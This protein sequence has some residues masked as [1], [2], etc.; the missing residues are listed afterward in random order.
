MEER[1]EGTEHEPYK[2][3]LKGFE[4]P[5]DLLLHLVKTHE[6]DIFDIPVAFITKKYLEYLDLM[7]TL[8]IDVAGE[9]VLMAA[10]LAHIKSRQMLPRDELDE[11]EEEGEDPRAELIRRLLEY[12]K[13]KDAAH[14]LGDLPQEGRSVWIRP[15]AG[16]EEDE[17]ELPPLAEIGLFQLLE[18]FSK[19]MAR[20]KPELTHDVVVDRVSL[21]TRI[22]QLADLVQEQ[23]RIT[24]DQA[25]QDLLSGEAMSEKAL[26]M[27]VV[28]TFLALLEMARLRMLR[29]WQQNPKGEI[30]LEVT[31]KDITVKPEDLKYDDPYG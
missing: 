6:L 27:E 3:S 11:E 26:R 18:A 19:V 21:A 15:G 9:F 12:Q 28:V 20:I 8:N 31:A 4:G 22:S 5:L 13:F 17:E 10:T 7:R 29:I 24:F 30:Y 1:R 25:F 14:Q 16:P 23:Q 2:V